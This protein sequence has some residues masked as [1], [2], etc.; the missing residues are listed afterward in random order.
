MRRFQQYLL[1]L[2]LGDFSAPNQ[3][4]RISQSREDADPVTVIL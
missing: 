3:R 2:R 1:D 4:N